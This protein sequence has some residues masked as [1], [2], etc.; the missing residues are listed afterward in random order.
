MA[1]PEITSQINFNVILGQCI[2]RSIA[3]A[4][5]RSVNRLETPQS[6]NLWFIAEKCTRRMIRFV[7]QTPPDNTANF[8]RNGLAANMARKPQ[9]TKWKWCLHKTSRIEMERRSSPNIEWLNCGNWIIHICPLIWF[10]VAAS[11]NSLHDRNGLIKFKPFA[12]ERFWFWCNYPAKRLNQRQHCCHYRYHLDSCFASNACALFAM[13]CPAQR[14]NA[15]KNTVIN[16]QND[17]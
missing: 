13:Q 17:T 2:C 8:V 15:N 5:N 14:H 3:G 9:N 7:R 4:G 6:V 16:H 11:L 10:S 1:L 12:R